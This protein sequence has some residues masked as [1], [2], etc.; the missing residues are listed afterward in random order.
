MSF[1][2]AGCGLQTR[3]RVDLAAVRFGLCGV[4][5]TI[6]DQWYQLNYFNIH[7]DDDEENAGAE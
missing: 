3:R 6:W 2:G 4:C 5:I 7:D 1:A